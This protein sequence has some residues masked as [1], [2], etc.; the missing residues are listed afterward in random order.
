MCN[1]VLHHLISIAGQADFS[2][3]NR[4]IEEARRVLRPLGVLIINTSSHRQLYD[5]FWWDDLIP[6][7]VGRIAERFPSIEIITSMLEEAGF[8][9][10]STIIPM[11]AVIQGRNYL[12]PIG[13]LKK[14]FRDGDST[15]S[16]ATDKELE[17][18]QARVQSMNRGEDMKDYLEARED[19]RKKTGQVTFIFSYKK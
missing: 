6:D 5:G 3:V 2:P 1:Q 18:A 7:A 10:V 8:Q 11:G 15:W 16:L 19:L 12:D 9:K 17:R 13:P 14:A 4:L